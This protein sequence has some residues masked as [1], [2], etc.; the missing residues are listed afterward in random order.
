MTGIEITAAIAAAAQSELP[1]LLGAEG[2]P[3]FDEY[4]NKSPKAI[5]DKEFCVYI[6]HERDS[7][8][9]RSLSVIIQCQLYQS[10]EDQAYHAVI[11]QWLL[12]TITSDFAGYQE[13]ESIEGDPWP[14]DDRSTAFL[15]YALEFKD[16][17]D[18]CQ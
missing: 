11:Y 14:L 4:R 13:R 7:T 12:D 18:D 6:E 9:A 8:D 16:D 10:D 15:Y 5:D 17:L 3:D 2:L 1:A